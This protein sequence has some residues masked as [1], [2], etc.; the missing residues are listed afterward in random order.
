MPGFTVYQTVKNLPLVL[1]K[2]VPGSLFA[3]IFIR[4]MLAYIMY[5]GFQIT[6]GNFF[7]A[8][9]GFLRHLTLL[10][11]SVIKRHQIQK[12]KVVDDAYIKSILHKGLPFK[13]IQRLKGALFFWRK[14]R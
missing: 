5:L 8:L 7:P 1:W 9:K 11:H 2:N 10:P 3:P 13:Q 4:F 14:G 6:K 12:S